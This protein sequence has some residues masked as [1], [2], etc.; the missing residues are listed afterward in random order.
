[1]IHRRFA[2][3]LVQRPYQT[4]PY[5]DFLKGLR[6]EEMYAVYPSFAFQSNSRSDNERFLLLDRFRR[7]CGGL[8]RL[9]LGNEFYHRHRPIVI[10]AHVLVILILILSFKL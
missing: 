3:I 4:V 6:D 5:D 8:K 10:G 7:L 9:Q 1:M 2:E